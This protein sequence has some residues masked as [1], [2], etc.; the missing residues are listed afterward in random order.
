ML[1]SVGYCT[2]SLNIAGQ[3]QR[4][5]QGDG[6]RTLTDLLK[7]ETMEDNIEA[8]DERVKNTQHTALRTLSTHKKKNP[9]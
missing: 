8:R 6:N 9:Q 1:N 3:L 5:G 7:H 2:I 4:C